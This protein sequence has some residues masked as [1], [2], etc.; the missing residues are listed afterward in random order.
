MSDVLRRKIFAG[1]RELGLDSDARSDLQ[2]LATGKS[3]LKD[4]GEADLKLVISALQDR[5]F[6]PS[7]GKRFKAAPRADLRYC[8]KLWSQL[9]KAGK[10]DKPGRAG[11]NTFVRS[12]FEQA[13]GSVPADIDMLRD[14]AQ[15]NAVVK[16]LQAW[17]R[18]V[19]I[20]PAVPGK[21]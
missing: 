3:S 15:I 6:K 2:K 7:K 12:Q 18:R 11:L 21:R 13:W 4:M 9:G 19:G 17:C 8:H 14:H 1:C 5:G 10:L 16:A 20:D